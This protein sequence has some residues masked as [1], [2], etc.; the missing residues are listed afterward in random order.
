MKVTQSRQSLLPKLQL[1]QWKLTGTLLG[2]NKSDWWPAALDPSQPDV[3]FDNLRV[4]NYISS[5]GDSGG[6][7]YNDNTSTL[8][9]SHK[10]TYTENGTVYRVYSHVT[11]I[12]N[13]LNISPVNWLDQ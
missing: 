11:N 13:R 6:T 12:A 9:G 4:A 8:K 2:K 7:I 10:G 1:K 5:G 3:W